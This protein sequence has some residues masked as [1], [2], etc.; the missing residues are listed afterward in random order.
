MRLGRRLVEWPGAHMMPSM[1]TLP[2]LLV[3]HL[4]NCFY[5]NTPKTLANLLIIEDWFYLDHFISRLLILS[6]SCKTCPSFKI[7]T[8]IVIIRWPIKRHVRNTG[9]SEAGWA[10]G[11]HS[12]TVVLCFWEE[13]VAWQDFACGQFGNTWNYCGTRGK[14]CR[15]FPEIWG[16]KITPNTENPDESSLH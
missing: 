15:V 14:K 3:R 6:N 12:A 1:P 8:Q 5:T 11:S 7:V 2:C 13:H 4:M 9:N 16:L 10:G